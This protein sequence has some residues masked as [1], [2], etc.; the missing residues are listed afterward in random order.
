MALF[1]RNQITAL[2]YHPYPL[3]RAGIR[4]WLARHAEI[5]GAVVAETGELPE[6]A[7]LI[8][9]EW[10]DLLILP[11][12]T[13]KMILTALTDAAAE[14]AVRTLLLTGF[15]PA[16]SAPALA[17][18]AAGDDAE[19]PLHP[20]TQTERFRQVLHAELARHVP[21]FHQV[22]A[23][24]PRSGAGPRGLLQGPWLSR[25]RRPAAGARQRT[26]P[27]RGRAEVA[28][29]AAGEGAEAAAGPAGTGA[30]A[31]RAAPSGRA[32]LLGGQ[33]LLGGQLPPD[34]DDQQ[35][36]P[37]GGRIFTPTDLDVLTLLAV[38]ATQVEIARMI[39][40]AYGTM[41]SRIARICKHGNAR[42]YTQAVAIAWAAGELTQ[43]MLT[44][45]AEW[46]RL[47]RATAPRLRRHGPQQEKANDP[48]GPA[49]GA[50]DCALPGTAL[51]GE[52]AAGP[53]GSARTEAAPG[54]APLPH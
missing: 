21:G 15:T 48:L 34:G 32:A 3:C 52:Q 43:D 17:G 53:S 28:G 49:P 45:A 2:V 33:Q 23:A 38:G 10:A 31:S 39:G 35:D 54:A 20:C 9:R 22:A 27:G 26:A 46:L 8:E 29:V 51:P 37:A 5:P 4:R 40:I 42:T 16:R 50:G 19:H 6:L 12:G 18:P 14:S 41:K 25:R 44:A 30:S 24:G 11:A 1:D 47:V 7:R 36:D 13:L